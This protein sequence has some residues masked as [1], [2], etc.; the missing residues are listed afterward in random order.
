[1]EHLVVN[2]EATLAGEV[3]TSGA[4][5]SSVAILPA[6]LMAGSP[7]TIENLPLIEDIITL[8]QLIQSLGA[9]VETNG[10]GSLT[11][12]PQKAHK[13]EASYELVSKLRAS[14]YF[15][16]SLLT[17]FKK[18]VIPLPGGCPL[19][20]RPM[21]QHIKGFQALGARVAIEHGCIRLEADQLKGTEIYLDIVSVGATINLMLASVTAQ[22]KT[23]LE[24]VAKEPEIVD[25][26]NF[27]NA[28]GADIVG[29][30]TD[31]IKIKGVKKLGGANHMVIPDRIEAGTFILAAA[32]TNS[33]VLV[34]E[35][36]PKHLEAVTA[37][38]KELG[39]DLDVGED[40]IKVNGCSCPKAINIKTFPYP[41]FPTDLQ[42]IIMPIMTKT[43]GISMITEN[44]FEGRFK[45]VDELKRMG[46][47]ILVEGRTA[48]VEGGG[49]LSGAPV[50]AT[51]LRAG[52]GLI[53]AGMMAKGETIISGIDHIDRGYE[54]IEGKFNKL[55]AG[56]KRIKQE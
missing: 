8:T 48:I 55:G 23:I 46:A 14:Y 41:G 7:V 16:G 12:Y 3:I 19:G 28:I 6:A 37:K 51:D 11:I 26:A 56:I 52:A 45:H 53:I 1:M 30:G 35:V 38:L 9:E 43:N 31:V 18:A 50:K 25:I 24:N 54:N 20:P 29:A 22:G 36:I 32:S 44:V 4:K 40:W 49:S 34:K 2:G 33:S 10:H 13:W 27:L 39:V 47:N 5:N 17:R 21:D 15:L 42:S